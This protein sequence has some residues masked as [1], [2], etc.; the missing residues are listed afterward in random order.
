MS[1]KKLRDFQLEALLTQLSSWCWS[2][3]IIL[4][5]CQTVPVQPQH[6][7]I[8]S[9]TDEDKKSSYSLFSN[10]KVSW[11][12][13][14]LQQRMSL[15]IFSFEAEDEDDWNSWTNKGLLSSLKQRQKMSRPH[16]WLQFC[17]SKE[18]IFLSFNL[19]RWV[20]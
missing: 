18:I 19:K 16:H 5:T 4:F 7:F 12:K 9:T 20:E 6:L 15:V 8:T 2:C 11:L 14:I 17:F 13:M 1:L 10:K 3:A